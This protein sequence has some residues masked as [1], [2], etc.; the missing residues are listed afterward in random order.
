MYFF[1][2]LHCLNCI[3]RSPLHC[4]QLI[5][6]SGNCTADTAVTQ[7]CWDEEKLNIWVASCN[8]QPNVGKPDCQKRNRLFLPVRLDSSNMSLTLIS[9]SQ[10]ACVMCIVILRDENQDA[11]L[12]GRIAREWG[13][14]KVQFRLDFPSPHWQAGVWPGVQR[15]LVETQTGFTNGYNVA[16]DNV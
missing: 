3:N 11:K 6:I 15:G 10:K 2:N 1:W 14:K 12:T 13:D 5:A 8:L 7:W 9:L 4:C 16:T